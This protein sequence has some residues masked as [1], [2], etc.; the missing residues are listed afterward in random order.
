[1]GRIRLRKAIPAESEFAYLV[2]KAA[3]KEYVEEV[4][5]WDGD[6]QRRLHRQRFEAQDFRVISVDGKDVGIM[7]VALTP[8][9]MKVNQLFLLPEH[10]GNGIGQDCMLRIV[11]LARRMGLPVRLRVLKVNVRAVVFYKRLEFR[12]FG[13]SETHIQMDKL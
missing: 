1:M 8:D 10:Q 7:A 5:G 6:E 3:F 11:R 2:K 9:C 13:E 4:W 12:C